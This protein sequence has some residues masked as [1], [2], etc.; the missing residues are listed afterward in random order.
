MPVLIS[1]MTDRQMIVKYKGV[2]SKPK[3]LTGGAPQGTLLGGIKYNITSGD[4]SVDTVAQKDRFRYYDD[5]EI[6]E[7]I[8]LNDLLVQYNFQEHIASDIGIDQLYLPSENYKMQG[9]LNDISEWTDKNLMEL[10]ERKSNYIIFTRSKSEFSTRLTLKEITLDRLSVTKLLGVWLQEDMG[11]ET[12][13]KQICKKAYSRI[14]IL[15]KLKYAGIQ[16]EDLVTIYKLFIRSVTEYCSVVFHTSL[17][18]DQRRRLE[19]IQST[20]LKLILADEYKDYESALQ[21]CSLSSLFERREKRMQTFALR[22][23]E[24]KFNK[25]LF[26]IN[27]KPIGGEKYRV[28]FARTSKYFQSAIPQCQRTLNNYNNHSK[29]KR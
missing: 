28:N 2:Q 26:P 11:W 24:D 23:T 15:G 14:P 8:V 21:K 6:L 3:P 25:S 16:N 1:Y 27:E 12:N 13:V 5:L 9:Y 19:T 22:C 20:S 7:F 17:T 10:N 18:Q 4:C 29:A